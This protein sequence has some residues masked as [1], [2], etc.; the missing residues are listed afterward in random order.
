MAKLTK[1]K[2]YSWDFE[3]IGGTIHCFGK[4]AELKYYGRFSEDV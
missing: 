1:S 3:N 4:I 2:G